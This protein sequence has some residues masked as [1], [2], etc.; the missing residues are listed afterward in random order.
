[1]SVEENF[2]GTHQHLRRHYGLHHQ[3]AG[4][5]IHHA[6]GAQRQEGYGLHGIAQP[7]G[8]VWIVGCQRADERFMQRAEQRSRGERRVLRRQMAGPH[9]GIDFGLQSRRRSRG[10]LRAAT[11]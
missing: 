4:A 3:T 7:G 6:D 2:L 10:G 9:R 11:R 1:M 5:G 8:I